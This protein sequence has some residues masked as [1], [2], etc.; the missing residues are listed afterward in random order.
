MKDKKQRVEPEIEAPLEYANSIIATL[1]EPFAK[2]ALIY[3]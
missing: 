1:R 2:N 3:Q